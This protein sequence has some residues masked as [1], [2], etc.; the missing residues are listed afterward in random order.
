MFV[1]AVRRMIAEMLKEGLTANEIA[2]RLGVARSTVGYHARVLQDGVPAPPEIPRTR[3]G[4][5]PVAAPSVTQR[6][7]K[8][9]LDAGHTHA[10]AAEK[11]GLAR[12]TITYHAARLGRSLDS[13]CSR[14]YDWQAIRKFYEEGHSVNE[15]RARFGFNRQSWHAAVLRGLVEPRPAR[16][17]LEELLVAGPRRNRNHIKQRLFD[18]GLKA[19]E[20]ESCG[21]RQWRGASLP[22]ALHH[23]NGDRHDNRLENLALLCPNCHSQTD[24]WAGRNGR[25]RPTFAAE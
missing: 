13:R 17:P 22:L 25:S 3:T 10:E 12:S 14:R 9:L 5:A 16:I 20:C 11:L 4:A 8:G 19:R 1:T 18:A 7:V 21:L 6:R 2:H 15:C 24:T 23:L